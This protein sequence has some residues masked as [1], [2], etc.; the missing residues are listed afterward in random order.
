MKHRV[1]IT[2]SKAGHYT[3]TIKDDKRQCVFSKRL[4]PSLFR[5]REIAAD[6]LKLQ[7]EI[8]AAHQYLMTI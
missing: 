3:L 8:E 6:W 5:A 4:I 7:Q 2:L 1:Y